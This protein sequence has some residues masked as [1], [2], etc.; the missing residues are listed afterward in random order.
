MV[1]NNVYESHLNPELRPSGVSAIKYFFHEV[2][3]EAG[4][5]YHHF[6]TIYI[7][8]TTNLL[9]MNNCICKQT[10]QVPYI[11]LVSMKKF[12]NKYTKFMFQ[13]IYFRTPDLNCRVLLLH[14]IFGGIHFRRETAKRITENKFPL[15][16]TRYTVLDNTLN[17]THQVIPVQHL[18]LFTSIG[19][20]V[21]LE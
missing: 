13:R 1:S 21:W 7:G 16:I 20:F 8:H 2:G 15:K 17:K 4:S 12:S 11:G 10:K 18:T 19:L 5:F 14:I 6:E 9:K 3:W